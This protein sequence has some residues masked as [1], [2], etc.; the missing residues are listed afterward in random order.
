M[1]LPPKDQIPE[2]VLRTEIITTAR[3]PLSGAPLS[4]SAYADLQEKLQ[5]PPPPPPSRGKL[6]GL[7]MLLKV[8]RALQMILPL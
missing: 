1:A 6:A 8:R 7:I 3:S 5:Q 4:A 2:E